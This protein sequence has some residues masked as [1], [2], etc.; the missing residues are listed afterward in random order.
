MS[1]LLVYKI[2]SFG[3]LVESRLNGFFFRSGFYFTFNSYFTV[4]FL[5]AYQYSVLESSP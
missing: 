1:K 5:E 2:V 4:H 3:G